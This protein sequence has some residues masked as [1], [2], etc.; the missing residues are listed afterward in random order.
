MELRII[1]NEIELAGFLKALGTATLQV[2][3]EEHIVPAIVEESKVLPKIDRVMVKPIN[4]DGKLYIP[5]KDAM[6]HFN[7]CRQ[8]LINYTHAGMP[9]KREGKYFLFCL[10]DIEPWIKSYQSASNKSKSHLNKSKKKLDI[11]KFAKWKSN[12]T[13]M[14][15]DVNKDEGKMLSLTYKY[16]TKNYG[17]VWE[18][19]KKDFY[20]ENGYT[21]ASTCQIAY[22]L[23]SKKPAYKNLTQSCLYTVLKMEN[24]K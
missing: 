19:S 20:H 15:R 5:T 3:P 23:E 7:L 24:E 10:D 16:M 11:S 1:G 14:C 12:L 4:D 8:T 18:Q 21:P 9:H 17:I 13:K 2:Q 6:T 22:W